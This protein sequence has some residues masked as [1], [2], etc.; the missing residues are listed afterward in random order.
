[1][2]LSESVNHRVHDLTQGVSELLVPFFLAGIGLHVNVAALASAPV[3]LMAGAVL[4]AAVVSK[5]IGCGLGA[6]RLGWSDASRIGTG[7]VPRGE[8]GMVVAQIGQSFG[9][10]GDHVYAVVVLMSV[11]TTLVAPP[12]LNLA[13]RGLDRPH[14]A[15]ERYTVG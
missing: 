9:V 7:M 12:L 8:V 6:I 11:A 4:L 14:E 1:M 2:A 10:I 13:Y 3:L 15:E 5:F